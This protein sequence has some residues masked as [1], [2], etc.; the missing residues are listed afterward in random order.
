[1]LD[2]AVVTV[3]DSTTFDPS[4]WR[5]WGRRPLPGPGRPWLAVLAFFDRPV[6]NDYECTSDDQLDFTTTQLV[7]GVV[8]TADAAPMR[9]RC[10]S[11]TLGTIVAP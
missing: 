1:M 6:P 7:G 3:S 10:R 2:D 8:T 9:R 11:S 5:T 4:P